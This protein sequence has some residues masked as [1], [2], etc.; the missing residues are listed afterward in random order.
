MQHN[1]RLESAIFGEIR[2]ISR[3]YYIKFNF[4]QKSHLD[5]GPRPFKIASRQAS[6]Q[7][8]YYTN[9]F[10]WEG[11]YSKLSIIRPGRSRLLEFRKKLVLVD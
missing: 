11:R 9:F 8:L 6:A 2:Y 3:K 4:L 5:F 7:A 1:L 10:K